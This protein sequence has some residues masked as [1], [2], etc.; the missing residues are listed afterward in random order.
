VNPDEGVVETIGINVESDTAR[1]NLF[2]FEKNPSRRFKISSPT[3]WILSLLD[4]NR[5]PGSH[6]PSGSLVV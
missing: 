4:L 2:I 5:S 6:S 1:T 3:N